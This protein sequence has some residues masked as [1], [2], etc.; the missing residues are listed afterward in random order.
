M[1]TEIDTTDRSGCEHNSLVRCVD[2][3]L[4][5]L[6]AE[7]ERLRAMIADFDKDARQAVNEMQSLSSRIETRRFDTWK[8]GTSKLPLV[9]CAAGKDGECY[10]ERCPQLRDDGPHP[11]CP[12]ATPEDDQ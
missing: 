7:I 5:A 2:C 11:Y 1:S 4:G 8:R 6:R 12:L 3:E 9:H 10:D